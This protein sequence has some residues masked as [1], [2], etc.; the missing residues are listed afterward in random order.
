MQVQEHDDRIPAFINEGKAFDEFDDSIAGDVRDPYPELAQSRR[1]TP[2]QRL[3]GAVEG[4]PDYFTIYRHAD[5]AQVLRD[6]ET[7]SSAILIEVMGPI[8]GEH[9]ILGMDAPEHR[10]HR[11][12]VSK[13][14]QAKIL[15]RWESEL[16]ERVVSDLI[17]GF[18]SD[19]R[20]ELVR[21]FTSHFPVMVIARVLGLPQEDYS[22]FQ[23]WTI[24]IVAASANWDRGLT[25]SRELRDYLAEVLRERRIKPHDDLISELATTELDGDRLSDEEIF[26]FLRLLLPAG[27]ETTYR[28]SGNLIYALLSHTDQLEA[29]RSDRSLIPQAI[30]EAL[31]WEPPL[32]ITSRVATRD[33]EIADVPIPAGSPIVVMLGSANRDETKYTDPD[34]FDIFRDPQQHMSFGNGPHLCLGMHLARLE[35][36]VALNGLL[37]RLPNLRLDPEGDDPHIHGQIF[38]SPTSLP[39]LFDV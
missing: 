8:M 39:V 16:I 34:R 29:V 19:G 25:A 13:S 11:A 15:A 2:V 1:A 3:P 31:R 5:V 10:R 28:S 4:A 36:R 9:I 18:A 23:R 38:R 21:Q 22:Q 12:L 37:D 26:S 20:A 7:F 14:F 24:A 33:T 35:T 32:L 27:A 6:G 17:D 30:E